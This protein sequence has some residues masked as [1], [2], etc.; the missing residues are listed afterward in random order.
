MRFIIIFILLLS[1]LQINAAEISTTISP[2]CSTEIGKLVDSSLA[3][4]AK[5]ITNQAFG[6]LEANDIEDNS[7][8]QGIMHNSCRKDFLVNNLSN[9]IMYLIFGQSV[10]DSLK[11]GINIFNIADVEDSEYDKITS[12]NTILDASFLIKAFSS[13]ISYFIIFLLMYVFA[14]LILSARGGK[15]D[16]AFAMNMI[17]ILTGISVVFPLDIFSGLSFV[18]FVAISAIMIGTLIASYTW[19]FSIFIIDFFTMKE[20][21]TSKEVLNGYIDDIKKYSVSMVGEPLFDNV[22]AHICEITSVQEAF[23]DILGDSKK[24]EDVINSSF[25]NCLRDKIINIDDLKERFPNT[26]NRFLRTQACFL[27]NEILKDKIDEN[28]PFC[29]EY[30]EIEND[31]TYSEM[32]PSSTLIDKQTIDPIKLIRDELGFLKD[33][34]QDNIRKIS[35]NIY[36]AICGI[37]SKAPIKSNIQTFYCVEQDIDYDYSFDEKDNIVK[38]NFSGDMKE[39]LQNLMKEGEI[40]SHNFLVNNLIP[41]ISSVFTVRITGNSSFDNLKSNLEYSIGNGWLGTPSIYFTTPILQFDIENI[42]ENV[43]MALDFSNKSPHYSDVWAMR[44]SLIVPSAK[45]ATSIPYFNDMVEAFFKVDVPTTENTIGKI[46]ETQN[47]SQESF[48]NF[49]ILNLF[50]IGNDGYYLKDCYIRKEFGKNEC[51]YSTINPFKNIVT[52]GKALMEVTDKFWLLT[53]AINTFTQFKSDEERKNNNTGF[54]TV[55]NSISGYL[56]VVFGTL[57]AIGA[58]F[59]I[60]LPLIPFLIFGSMIVGWIV[61]AFRSVLA[62]QFLVINYFIPNKDDDM[63]EGESKIYTLILNAVFTPFFIIMGATVSFILIHISIGLVNVSFSLIVE[64]FNTFDN[65]VMHSLSLMKIVDNIILYIVYLVILTA[66]I[67]NACSAMYK[68]PETI[69]EWFGIKIDTNQGMF[70]QV[71]MVMQKILF[72][73]SS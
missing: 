24:R 63:E 40:D 54:I 45:L 37:T 20:S 62:V 30:T 17:K 7:N 43:I 23:E 70:Q 38:Y 67:V 57:T 31:T 58:F 4:S 65:S 66:M 28:E 21:L 47:K 27:E 8:L 61:Q 25:Y 35:L 2:E 22:N 52:D 14:K 9:K 32:F 12:I 50:D 48:V 26:P 64:F 1:S 10:V 55:V 44:D 42:A 49:S 53:Y 59:G 51:L 6:N 33:D 73:Q 60:A 46:Q 16:K 18:Q 39:S 69:R 29:G 41:N 11:L 36:N 13:I 15:V 71:R 34:Y 68:V 3:E 72:I 5:E 19:A 56:S